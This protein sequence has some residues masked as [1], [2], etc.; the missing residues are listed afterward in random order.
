[1]WWFVCLVM[2][3]FVCA[4]WQSFGSM[5]LGP[6]GI[7]LVLRRVFH[8]TRIDSS[9]CALPWICHTIWSDSMCTI[10]EKVIVHDRRALFFFSRFICLLVCQYIYIVQNAD[11]QIYCMS[12]VVLQRHLRINILVQ[13]YSQDTYSTVMI[14]GKCNY[15]WKQCNSHNADYWQFL[16]GYSLH[17]APAGG[18]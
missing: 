14:F 3:V 13:L 17:W 7:Q 1:M 11:C 8:S 4:N 6:I 9:I 12:Y 15:T 5:T 16:I 2:Y 18:Q 10:P